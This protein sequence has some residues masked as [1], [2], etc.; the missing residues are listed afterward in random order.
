MV[1]YMIRGVSQSLLRLFV[2]SQPLIRD[3]L[4]GELMKSNG[5]RASYVF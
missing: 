4:S 2:E 5:I 1:E 3:P